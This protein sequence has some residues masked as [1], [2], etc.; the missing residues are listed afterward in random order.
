[1]REGI[2]AT[3]TWC[4]ELLQ[5]G[6]AGGAA[7][8]GGHHNTVGP[9]PPTLYSTRPG[10]GLCNGSLLYQHL[11]T[12]PLHVPFTNFPLPHTRAQTVLSQP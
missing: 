12:P 9:H 1:M 4:Q 6:P 10:V 3:H 8:G 2:F 7:T 11:C 5:A